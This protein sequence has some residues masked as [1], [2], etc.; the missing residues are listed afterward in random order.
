MGTEKVQV[1][2]PVQVQVR[3]AAVVRAQALAVTHRHGLIKMLLRP[4]LLQPP[5]QKRYLKQL[6]RIFAR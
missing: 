3:G 2:V 1:Q 6:G 5:H 4:L